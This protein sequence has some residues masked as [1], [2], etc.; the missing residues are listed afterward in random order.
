MDRYY[1]L[2]TYIGEALNSG[3]FSQRVV[4]YPFGELGM[5]VKQILNWRYGIQEEFI[6]DE[7]L[8]KKNPQIKSLEYLSH[9]DTSQYTFI[10]TSENLECYDEIRMNL[11]KYVSEKNIFD[12]FSCKPLVSKEPRIASLELASREIYDRN[13][14]GA[15]AEAGVYQGYFAAFI[16]RFFKDRKLYLFD[17]FEGFDAQDVNRDKANGYTYADASRY[18]GTSVDLVLG[19]MPFAENVVIKKGYFPDTTEGI[20]EQFCFVS[21]DMDLYQPIKAGL[22][23]FYPRLAGGGYIFVHDCNIGDVIYRG[24]RTALLEFAER[25]KTGYVML[26]D[27]ATA[28][29]TKNKSR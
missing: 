28:V 6:I 4:L 25:E 24:P 1:H 22:E 29:I 13:I 15:V 26:P 2:N 12:L 8:S 19:R 9:I 14:P 11:R 27:N 16:N 21:L 17:T 20:C 7:N 18:R 10:I 23:Y 5:E 3:N